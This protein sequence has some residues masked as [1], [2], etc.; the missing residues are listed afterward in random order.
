[1]VIFCKHIISGQWWCVACNHLR[2][3]TF[4]GKPCVLHNL[5]SLR[6]FN[7]IWYGYILGQDGV[8]HALHFFFD[9][10]VISLDL[11]LRWNLVGYITFIHFWD[12]LGHLAQSVRLA[13]DAS[14]TSN[15][16]VMSFIPAR[17]HSLVEIDYEIISSV[18]LLLSAE[19]F[20]K[21]C[22]QLQAKVSA[23]SNG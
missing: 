21:G 1:M 15:A 9:V 22:C 6:H 11:I 8:S 2:S 20:K 16:G 12:I 17:S 18:I 3:M 14:L 13:T 23:Q 7:D 4:K 10:W 5:Y 19:S